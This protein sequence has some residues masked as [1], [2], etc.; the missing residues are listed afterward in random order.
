LKKR[1]NSS[2]EKTPTQSSQEVCATSMDIERELIP[3]A[4]GLHELFSLK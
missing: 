2:E 4:Y 1:N 3:F